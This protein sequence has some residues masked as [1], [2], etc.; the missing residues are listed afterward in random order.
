MIRCLRA[1]DLL[2]A[3]F[4]LKSRMDCDR[5]LLTCA[6]AER[7]YEEK[8]RLRRELKGFIQRVPHLKG[9]RQIGPL[10]SSMVGAHHAGQLPY[11]K[12]VVEEMMNKG[13]LDAIFSTST[14]A[15]GVNFPARTVVL[16]QSDRFTGREFANLTAT[17]LHQMTGR[18]G[19]RGKDNIGFA[20]VLPGLHQ[21]PKYLYRLKDSPPEPLESRIHINFS[22]VLNLLL[23]HT[24]PQVQDLLERSFA[25]FQ[26]RKTAS[27]LQ[28][29]WDE[30]LDFLRRSFAG[31]KCDISDPYEVME[32]IQ[33][34]TMLRRAAKRTARD[35]RLERVTEAYREV[36]VPGRLILHKNGHIYCVFHTTMER[37][38]L[39]AA[40]HNLKRR[41]KIKHDRVTLKKVEIHQIKAV[42]D[43]VVDLA[44]PHTPDRLDPI[45]A[46]VPRKELPVLGLNIR[47]ERT[48]ESEPAPSAP[49]S[50][51]PCE[52]CDH[53]RRCLDVEKGDFRKLF[54]RFRDLLPH[55]EGL[56]GGLW[57]SFKRHMR[58]L[59]ETGFIDEEAH[60]TVDG[61]WASKL[62]LDHPLLIAEAIR[63][64]SFDGVSPEVMAGCIAP[65]V[66]DRSQEVEVR[67][68]APADLDEMKSAYDRMIGLIE[69]IRNSVIRRGFENPQILFWPAAALFL[70]AKRVP[71]EEILSFIVVDE[72]DMVSLIMRTADHLRQVVNL[73]QTHPEL[74]AAAREAIGLIMREPVYLE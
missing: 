57:I 30:M 17:E 71:W 22:M 37:G 38:K 40:A 9:H 28:A 52:E 49:D 7:P 46:S 21:D 13:Y 2:P 54:A 69:E 51:L 50:P 34:R 15:A 25:S 62:R 29:E 33:K 67:S 55:L 45:F 65:F 64:G 32:Q 68:I 48:A 43:I 5:A 63:K 3:I 70:W 35:R 60:L 1:F 12:M 44:G 11:W 31:G 66:W 18:A 27:P 6:P 42:F 8:E 24:P 26:G 61:R 4:F 41:L 19:R 20:V 74:A 36:L 16:V 47:E 53:L 56:K 59:R 58:F 39:I 73:E 72:G 10:L 23:S 14:V